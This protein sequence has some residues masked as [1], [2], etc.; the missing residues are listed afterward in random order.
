MAVYY[1]LLSDGSLD[2]R[3]RMFLLEKY[4]ADR[5]VFEFLKPHFDNLNIEILNKNKG[6][7]FDLMRDG[8]LE[9]WCWQTTETAILFLDDKSY[10]ERGNLKI[11]KYMNYYHSWIVFKYKD[12][13]YVFDPCLNILIDKKL[14]ISIFNTEIAA[15]ILSKDVKKYF[16]N[17]MNE[18]KN[19]KIEK[20]YIMNFFSKVASDAFE[21]QKGEIMMKSSED[22]NSPMYRNNTGYKADISDNKILSLT[23]HYYFN[24]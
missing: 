8:H 24:G 18:N 21:R 6:N 7:I 3:Q 4:K 1:S 22:I 23:A 14:Y 13:D 17:Y 15:D 19:K 2:M 9:G 16:I 5:E 11:G 12:K 20:S 10:I